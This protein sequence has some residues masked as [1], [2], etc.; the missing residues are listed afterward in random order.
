[1]S[2]R[3][4]FAALDIDGEEDAPQAPAAPVAAAAPAKVL[5]PTQPQ[6][7]QKAAVSK[8]AEKPQGG[9][10]TGPK[11]NGPRPPRQ[12]EL[13]CLSFK[14]YFLGGEKK[15][16]AKS[17]EEGVDVVAEKPHREHNPHAHQDGSKRGGREGSA[18]RNER[19]SH[20]R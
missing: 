11:S 18:F 4:I 10:P 6:A 9:K 7:S 17:T 5:K 8:S 20:Q 1:M 16:V 13:I 3:N 19:H 14:T 2:T 15:P 12:G